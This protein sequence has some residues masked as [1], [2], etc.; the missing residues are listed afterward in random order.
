E[1]AAYL[2]AQG[3]ERIGYLGWSDGSPVGKDR[4]AGWAG[5]LGLSAAA[6]EQ[7]AVEVEDTVDDGAEG[8]KELL[9]RGA[10]AVVCASD[11]LSLGAYTVLRRRGASGRWIIGFDNTP[12]A[13][14]LGISSM[15]QPVEDVAATVLDMVLRQIADPAVELR[16]VLVPPV[17][18]ARDGSGV[19]GSGYTDDAPAPLEGNTTHAP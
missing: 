8:M 12:V 15:V 7:L 13:R 11:T 6:E 2:R 1:A 19:I 4:R 10:T 17:L 16:G 5:A 9:A 18:V 14:E 3:H